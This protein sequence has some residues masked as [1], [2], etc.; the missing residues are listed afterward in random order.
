MHIAGV[1]EVGRG[2]LAG[3]VVAAAVV[4]DLQK[5]VLGLNDSKKLSAQ[6]RAVLYPVILERALSVGVAS[7]SA[8]QIDE[9]NI[10]QA[11]LW[12]MKLAVE[13]LRVSVHEV[14]VD[15]NQ[16]IPF[17]QDRHQKTFVGG[18]ALHA[19]IMAASI[20]AKV[21]RDRLM[22][23]FSKEYPQYGFEGHKGYGTALHL[24]AIAEHGPCVLHRR[25]FEPIR[26]W[27]V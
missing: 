16:R 14:W 17:E 7:V 2:P 6:K 18:D 12:A 26:S 3:P 4:L 5:P 10:L 8:Q 19:C 20:V 24:K 27:S 25:S 11:S 9:M 15:G 1:D 23:Q 13:Q 22:L 21:H